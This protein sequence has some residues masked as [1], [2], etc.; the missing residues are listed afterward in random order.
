MSNTS[1]F[2]YCVEMGIAEV[3]E[4]FHLAFKSEDRYPH[5]VGPITVNLSGRQVTVNVRV[6]D[7]E[8]RHADLRFQDERHIAFAFPFELTAETP[9]APDPSLSRITLQAR[10]EIP[11]LLTSWTEDADEVLGLDFAGVTPADVTIQE[12]TGVP[13]IDV[14]NFRN[15]IHAK[16][17]T[18]QHT[19]TSGGSTLVIY[20]DT[21]DSTLV[22]PNAAAPFE[23][24]ADLESHGGDDYLKVEIPIHVS[25]PI[26]GGTTYTS[27]GRIRFWRLVEQS[28]TTITVEMGTE[29]A[30]PAL[31]TTVELDDVVGQQ[32]S[33]IA[34]ITA[35]IHA[36]YQLI[37]HV[38]T[39]LAGNTL[40]LYDGTLD[41]SLTPPNYAT[42]SEIEAE[43]ETHSGTEYLKIT[44]PFHITVPSAS[45]ASYGRF[46][47]WRAVTRTATTMSINMAAE[48][49]DPA[50]QT[51]IELDTDHI[52]KVAI[53]TAMKP[54]VIVA[55]ALYGTVSGDSFGVV[56]AALKTASI[57]AI[58]GFGTITE[59]AFTQSAAENLLKEQISDYIK[60]RRYPV[61]TPRSGDPAH[62][63][64]TPVGFLLTA[65]DILAV[66][67]NRRTGTAA[68]DVAPDNFLG[69]N[70]LALATSRAVLDE[71]IDEAIADEF[72]GV[73]SGGTD[74]VHTD[75]GDATLES[76]NVT[77]SDP[78]SHGESE[79]HLWIT[80]EAEVHIDCWPDPDVSFEG[81]VFIDAI[82]TEVDGVCGLDLQGRAGDFDFDESCCDVFVDLLIPIVGWIMLGVIEHTIDQVGGELA[83]DITDQQAE[84]IEPIPPVIN[85]IAEVSAC[86]TDVF[87][88]S[89]GLVFPGTMT[90]RRLGTSFEDLRDDADLPRP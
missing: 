79:G 25:V 57:N 77:P 55:I 3:K 5:N 86:L 37:S 80:G 10:V 58:N 46:I 8:D 32:A 73:A 30:L 1:N 24:Q 69:S 78:G 9:D 18:Q 47:Y 2:D 45:Y 82:P 62:P 89:E 33:E 53:I 36:Q 76:L 4:I 29:P 28:D 65:D 67:L 50:L 90:I 51:T 64:N 15:A 19:Y 85:G 41:T 66:L 48:P 70:Q 21:R 7:D 52:A 74:T 11:A 12:L 61:F 87:I 17:D 43:F 22:P 56:L 81:P 31:A 13:V 23:I 84:S 60:V 14:E 6:L 40:V 26:P 54:G 49:V 34:A 42:P 63:L 39:D 72:P 44:A 38:H 75:E 71:A 83:R 35:G 68:D 88:S 27:F 20:D 59:P 16:Y